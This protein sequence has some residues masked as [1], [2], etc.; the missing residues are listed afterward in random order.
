MPWAT[1]SGAS[2]GDDPLVVGIDLGWRDRRADP[3]VTGRRAPQ[4]R[5]DRLRRRAG[6]GAC[7]RRSTSG[8][9]ACAI[10]CRVPPA[11]ADSRSARR[12]RVVV[13]QPDVDSGESVDRFDD[14]TAEPG[15]EVADQGGVG[16][17]HGL[18][19]EV[20]QAQGDD[21]LVQRPDPGRAV[22][23]PARRRPRPGRAGTSCA[24]SARRR[25]GRSAAATSVARRRRRRASAAPRR[26]V[27]PGGVDRPAV[28]AAAVA[29]AQ[30][31]RRA[32][33][34]TRPPTTARSSGPQTQTSAPRSWVA[35]ISPTVAS[36]SACRPASGSVTNR[37]LSCRPLQPSPGRRGRARAAAGDVRATV[38][39]VVPV[40]LRRRSAAGQHPQAASCGRRRSTQRGERRRRARRP[41]R[42]PATSGKRTSR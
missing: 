23:H 34:V 7:C 37:T 33:A 5:T 41:R 38:S 42:P 13:D 9:Y 3:E 32:R 39:R 25:A 26:L 40:L 16:A 22:G 21:L 19:A 1:S 10:T 8:R 24:G 17:D 11:V 15:N 20:G 4:H 2:C 27:P 12:A 28:V 35:V 36:M 18:R 31:I 30:G 29:R 14:G 6:R